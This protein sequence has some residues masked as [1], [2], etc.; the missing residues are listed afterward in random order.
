[1]SYFKYKMHKIPFPL[2]LCPTPLGE[3]TALSGPLDVFKRLTSNG[4][5]GKGEKRRGNEGRREGKGGARPPNILAQNRPWVEKRTNF[6]CASFF[7]T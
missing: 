2:G 5:E 6:V 4:R 7:N 1:M 3:L